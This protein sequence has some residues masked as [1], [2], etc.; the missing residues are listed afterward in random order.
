MNEQRSHTENASRECFDCRG[1]GYFVINL[2][3]G[4]CSDFEEC[5]TCHGSGCVPVPQSDEEKV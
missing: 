5:E 3:C 1:T 4:C 2:S